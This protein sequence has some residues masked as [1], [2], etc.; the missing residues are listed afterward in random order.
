MSNS[1]YIIVG[2]GSSGAVLAARL[3]EDPNITVTLV[4][5]G[6]RERNVLLEMPIAFPLVMVGGSRFN[7]SYM[8]EPEP[9][10]N[11]R[12]IGRAHV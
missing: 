11:N 12:Q 2:A 10:A 6:R 9:F 3:T 4:E 8:G 5:A 7:W 1:D